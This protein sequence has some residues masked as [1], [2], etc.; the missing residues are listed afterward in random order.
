MRASLSGS[1]IRVV[2]VRP[3]PRAIRA[4]AR[5][6]MAAVAFA[7]PVALAGSAAAN[8]GD[9]DVD[10]IDFPDHW[11]AQAFFEAHDP[12]NDPYYLDAD[13]DWIACEWNSW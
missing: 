12:A 9:Y 6:L 5:L 3:G 4:A 11:S 8:H 7:A 13:R 1:G 2:A 10:C